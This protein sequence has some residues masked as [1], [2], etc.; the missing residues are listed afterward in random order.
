MASLHVAIPPHALTIRRAN[1]IQAKKAREIMWTEWHQGQTLEEWMKMCDEMDKCDFTA[2][3]RLTQWVLVPRDDPDTDEILAS[4][5][6]Y[7]RKVALSSPSISVSEPSVGVGYMIAGVYVRAHLRRNGYAA[8]MMRLMHHVL[9]SPLSLPQFPEAWGAPPVE[10][11][12]DATLCCLYTDVGEFYAKCGPSLD[13]AGW[14]VTNK[15]TTIWKTAN[16]TLKAT[17]DGVKLLDEVE[18]KK[19]SVKDEELLLKELSH[20]LPPHDQDAVQRFTFLPTDGPLNFQLKLFQLTASRRPSG[21]L[22]WPPET[23]G[24]RLIKPFSSNI[25]FAGWTFELLPEPSRLIVIRIRCDDVSLPK[26]I[27]AAL[28][29]AIVAGLEEV[30]VWSLPDELIEAAAISGGLTFERKEHWPSVMWYGLPG[31][32]VQWMNNER[33][34]CLDLILQAA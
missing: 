5:E 32:E 34:V 15:R 2:S 27:S 17:H 6:T 28:D 10:C 8:H 21:A 1:P 3:G 16:H 26:L 13:T 19:L 11:F 4:C 20:P 25:V 30:E 22:A 12:G 18:L 33:Q 23:Y 29:V 14:R 7:R 24:A 9:G 31:K